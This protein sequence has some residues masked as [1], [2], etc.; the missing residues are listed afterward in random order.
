[1][2]ENTFTLTLDT[3][4]QRGEQT[5]TEITLRKPTAGELRGLNLV[6]LISI[7]VGA[8]IE[9][10]PRI[11]TPFLSKQ[12]AAALD[13]ADLMQLG[14]VVAGFLVPK[15]RDHADQATANV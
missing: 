14:A 3:P 7:D 5:I 13:P 8:I 4:I 6:S 2:T 15:Q 10:L 11:T 9:I 12:D 1:M